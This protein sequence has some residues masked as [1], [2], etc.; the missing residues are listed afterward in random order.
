MGCTNMSLKKNAIFVSPQGDDGWSGRLPEPNGEQTDGPFATLE[1]ARD[2]IRRIKNDK[3][4]P[5]DGMTIYLRGGVYAREASL[6][7]T[8][9]ESGSENGQVIWTAYP[10]E[11]VRIAGAKALTEWQPV[12]DAEILKRLPES[13]RSN[14][15]VADLSA[16]GL[17]EIGEIAQ[18]GQPDLELYFNGKRMPRTRWPEE[19]W[20]KIA[21]V[22]QTGPKRFHEGLER[23]KRFDGVPVGRHYGRISYAEDRPSHW[24]AENDM[25]LHGY[26]T[27]D[28]N[29]A[30]QKI[31]PSM[32]RK[33]RSRWRNRIIN[34]GYTKNQRYHFINILEELDATGKWYL[35]RAQG[36]A[37]LLASGSR[38][39]RRYFRLR[40]D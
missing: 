29:D 11:D 2:E 31:D 32:A 33:R 26:F 8:E 40:T 30:Y 7:L 15:R 6:K 38:W 1:R 13:A 36:I 21:D 14:V 3:K 9:A 16:V 23:E 18:R 19:G 34:Y 37:L 25:Y 5:A 27:W 20:L 12:T 10:G 17:G 39:S 28:W 4:L 35:D 22:P 24:S